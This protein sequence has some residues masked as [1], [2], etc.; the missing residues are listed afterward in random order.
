MAFHLA[1]TID[2]MSG[3]LHPEDDITVVCM[4][5]GDDASATDAATAAFRIASGR[6]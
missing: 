6:D 2:G 5:V 3:S 4:Q 1:A